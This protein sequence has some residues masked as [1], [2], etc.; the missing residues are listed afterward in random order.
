MKN[1][2]NSEQDAVQ[3]LNPRDERWIA[4]VESFPRATIFH[5]PTWI[6]LLADCYGY[7]PFVIAMAVEGDKIIAGLPFIDVNSFLTD[8]RWTSLPFTDYCNPL[9]RDDAA[10]RQ[11][12]DELVQLFQNK[13]NPN[14]EVRWELPA[15]TSIHTKSE[16]V[17]HTLNLDQGIESISKSLHRTQRQNIKT[18][19]KNNV[20]IERGEDLESLRVFY[21]L[22]T[23]T[24]RRQ[25][26]PVQPWRFFKLLQERLIA[27]G[28]GF[29]L[30]AYA[31][32]QCLAAGLFL[33]WQKTLIYKYAAS[34]DK[35]QDLRPNHLLTWTAL[36]WGCENGYKI[37]D[38]GRTDVAN[39]GL[40]SFKNRWGTIETP[41]TYSILSAKP[42]NPSSGR[43]EVVMHKVIQN[44]P[45]WVCRLAGELL[46]RHFG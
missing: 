45:D 39:E 37:F 12:S 22:H 17:Q 2:N 28:L 6:D 19:E 13:G 43:M 29:V 5:H 46:Y 24:R 35:G 15:C 18:A 8:R 21:Q 42:Q 44:S 4:F 33:H 38:F 30:I 23:L 40:R 1:I 34:S 7:R 16:Y 36:N 10:F 27:R 9:Y 41:L 26:V 31:G 25:G 20:I 32:D 14:I 3:I 11:L